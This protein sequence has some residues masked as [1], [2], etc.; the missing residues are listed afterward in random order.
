MSYHLVSLGTEYLPIG[1]R[2]ETGICTAVAITILYTESNFK[3]FGMIL[4]VHDL[5]VTCDGVELET[6]GCFQRGLIML[7]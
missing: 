7:V 6:P 4:A 5:A 2:R 3:S 1:Q